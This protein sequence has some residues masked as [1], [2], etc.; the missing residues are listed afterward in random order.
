MNVTATLNELRRY[1][2]DARQ[3]PARTTAF[4]ERHL[5][6][7]ERDPL[8]SVEERSEVADVRAAFERAL[9]DPPSIA[10]FLSRD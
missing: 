6:R 3:S 1:V 10:P 7:W 5:K 4:I 9:D 2:P 8:L